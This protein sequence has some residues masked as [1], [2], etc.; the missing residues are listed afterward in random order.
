MHGDAVRLLAK[1]PADLGGHNT[2]GELQ[3]RG[4]HLDEERRAHDEPAPAT[5][6]LTQHFSAHSPAY[7]K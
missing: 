4:E 5:L 6:Q 1:M 7:N 3:S 2:E